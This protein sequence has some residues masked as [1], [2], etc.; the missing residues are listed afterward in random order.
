MLRG[1]LLEKQLIFCI[2]RFLGLEKCTSDGVGGQNNVE[3]TARRR[4]VQSDLE[5]DVVRVGQ[6]RDRP[7]NIGQY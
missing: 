7:T 2:F 3:G 1:V 4:C 5:S 6:Q